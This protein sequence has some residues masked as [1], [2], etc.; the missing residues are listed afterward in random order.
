[1]AGASVVAR[2]VVG[3]AGGGVGTGIGIAVGGGP[4]EQRLALD[5]GDAATPGL[6]R[7]TLRRWAKGQLQL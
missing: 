1:M 5:G 4:G 7:L 3:S 2:Y 6:S